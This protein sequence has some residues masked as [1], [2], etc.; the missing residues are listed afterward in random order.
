M[1]TCANCGVSQ[2]REQLAEYLSQHQNTETMGLKITAEEIQYF[3][4]GL[5]ISTHSWNDLTN[6]DYRD[7]H[8]MLYIGE[9]STTILIPKFAVSDEFY[10]GVM[11]LTKTK[12]VR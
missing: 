4:N 8:F 1:K 7:D 9:P 5:H 6:I 10:D 3:E 11:E 12:N 2:L